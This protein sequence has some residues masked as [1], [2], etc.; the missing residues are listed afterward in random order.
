MTFKFTGGNML[1]GL[2]KGVL[3]SVINIT[4]IQRVIYYKCWNF[5]KRELKTMH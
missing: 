3:A 4:G 2:G 5:K 1:K